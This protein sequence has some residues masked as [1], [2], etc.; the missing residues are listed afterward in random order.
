LSPEQVAEARLLVSGGLSL[1]KTGLVFETSHS[2]IKK[3]INEYN[4]LG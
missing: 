1:R 2:V 3:A 4:K